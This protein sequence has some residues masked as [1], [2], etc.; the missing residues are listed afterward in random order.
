MKNKYSMIL[1]YVTFI[2]MSFKLSAQ[3][4][5]DN[6]KLL[7]SDGKL[8]LDSLYKDFKSKLLIEKIIKADGKNVLEIKNLIKE[9]GALKSRGLRNI[10]TSETENLIT[11][12]VSLDNGPMGH[13]WTY[14]FEF[15]IKEG[16]FKFLIYDM[17]NANSITSMF[18]PNSIK[19]DFF[20][21]D[22]F[23]K[24]KYKVRTYL[25]TVDDLYHQFDSMEEYLKNPILG[26]K[27]KQNDW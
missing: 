10:L 16:R 17:G 2:L 3:D 5:E 6:H 20:M 22:G 1:F 12:N 26:N 13:S 15:L 8:Y 11:F 19:M 27:S 7:S 18:P 21:S 24:A 14:K 25:K 9:W 23:M 4:L